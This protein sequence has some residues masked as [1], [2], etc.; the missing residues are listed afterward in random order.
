MTDLYDRIVSQRGSLERLA[1]K[2][3]GFR[4]YHDRADRRKADRLLRDYIAGQIDQCVATLVQIEKLILDNIGLQY[5]PKTRDLKGKIQLYRD[6]VSAAAPGYAGLWAQMKIGLPE[7]EELYSFDEAQT[8][9]VEKV[10]KA[11]DALRKA[12][13]SKEGIDAAIMEA[14]SVTTEALDALALRDDVL[15]RFAESV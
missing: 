11:L 15:T 5:M 2:I 12:V 1:D 14:D 7:L 4:G 9:Y 6:K 8:R 13:L 3:P 10:D